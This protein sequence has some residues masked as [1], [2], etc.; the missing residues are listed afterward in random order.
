MVDGARTAGAAV[1][2]C[3]PPPFEPHEPGLPAEP[4]NALIERYA[5]CLEAL[6][7]EQDLL[8]IP[9]HAVFR[10]VH[11][12]GDPADPVRL[13]HDGVHMSP[14]GRYLMGLTFLAAFGVSV[15]PNPN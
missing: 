4:A 14:T 3:T 8:L 10:L 11:E 9:V 7:D 13:T 12:A 2:L 6:A 1:A 5:G 15:E